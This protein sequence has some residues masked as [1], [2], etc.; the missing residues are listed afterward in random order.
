MLLI[1]LCPTPRIAQ[2]E[3]KLEITKSKKAE[4]EAAAKPTVS[5]GVML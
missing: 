3:L 2:A 4:A 5:T 1:A